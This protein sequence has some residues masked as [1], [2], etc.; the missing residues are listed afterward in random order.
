MRVEFV[1]IKIRQLSAKI[2]RMSYHYAISWKLVKWLYSP[3]AWSYIWREILK[4]VRT[5]NFSKNLSAFE[6]RIHAQFCSTIWLH[7]SSVGDAVENDGPVLCNNSPYLFRMRACTLKD[8]SLSGGEWCMEFGVN[9]L[10]Y[11]GIN[12]KQ[13]LIAQECKN[14][15]IRERKERNIHARKTSPIVYQFGYRIKP[16]EILCFYDFLSS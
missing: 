4:L 8:L 12:F 9:L 16:S 15:I 14:G 11:L 13:I 3:R 10:G 1:V 2:S 7:N 5:V 6:P